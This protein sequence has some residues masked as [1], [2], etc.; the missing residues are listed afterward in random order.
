MRR[1]WWLLLLVVVGLIVWMV[2]PRGD[3]PT[4]EP[5]P[6]PTPTWTPAARAEAPTASSTPGLTSTTDTPVVPIPSTLP[7]SSTSLLATY[8]EARANATS[9]ERSTPTEWVDD[10]AAVTTDRWMAELRDRAQYGWEWDQFHTEGWHVE[11]TDLRCRNRIDSYSEGAVDAVVDCQ[12]TASLVNSNGTRASTQ[13]VGW[14]P[15]PQL[16]VQLN[17][18]LISGESNGLAG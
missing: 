11:I 8:I 7:T 15:R 10:V 14:D 13:P 9:A 5:N 16:T 2:F 1:T 12:Y 18:G 4:P 6:T 17:D 3:D